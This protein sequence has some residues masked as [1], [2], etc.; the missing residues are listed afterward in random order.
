M[1]ENPCR[2]NSPRKQL[3]YYCECD[4]Y[5]SEGKCLRASEDSVV[6]NISRSGGFIDTK[7]FSFT[8]TIYDT[9]YVC[10]EFFEKP[11]CRYEFTKI[12]KEYHRRVPYFQTAFWEVNTYDNFKRDIFRLNR[13]NSIYNRPFPPKDISIP[14]PTETWSPWWHGAKWIELHK[15][16]RYW[17]TPDSGI[18]SRRQMRINQYRN[19]AR[20]VDENLSQMRDIIGNDLL[21]AYET[22]ADKDSCKDCSDRKF[23]IRIEAWSDYRPVTRG[24]YLSK[25]E[26]EDRIAYAECEDIANYSSSD[27]PAAA[28]KPVLIQNGD[29][30][31]EYNTAL[32]KLRAFFGFKEIIE[33]LALHDNFSKYSGEEILTPDELIDENGKL[34]DR[35]II[36]KMIE[37]SRIIIAVKGYDT[38]PSTP[39]SK[40]Q[41][42]Y[43][44]AGARVDLPK[45]T[46]MQ[47]LSTFYNLDT[48]RTLF[49]VVKHLKYYNGRMIADSC[50]VDSE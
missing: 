47:K 50:C 22:I 4:A 10:P 33:T 38:D 27:N 13:S 30:L 34:L 26:D 37:K 6:S 7:D 43:A 23:I 24:W 25:S 32:S 8:E 45:Y 31:G 28:F 21:P 48:V 42:R 46:K 2:K 14:P 17:Q 19:F 12:Q 36:E 1:L 39:S 16:N 49:V 29:P 44:E 35:E 3:E 18:S 40:N 41:P 9:I 11:L 15:M 5:P 20:T